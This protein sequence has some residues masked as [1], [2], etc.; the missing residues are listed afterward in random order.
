MR[1]LALL[2]AVLSVA[3]A[4]GALQPSRFAFGQTPPPAGA[5]I[6]ALPSSTPQ[7]APAA[8]PKP[9]P[10]ASK[11]TGTAYGATQTASPASRTVARFNDAN[12]NFRPGFTANTLPANDDESTGLL[13]IGFPINFF[14]HSYSSLYVNNNGNVTFAAPLSAYTPFGLSGTNGVIIAPF[15]ADVDTSGDGSAAVT[16][17]NGMVDGRPAFGVN[18]PGV[19]YFAGHTDKLN[20]FQLVLIDRSNDGAPGDFDIEFNYDRVQWESGDVSGGTLGLGGSS[21]HVGFSNGSTSSFELPG[22]G[23][24]GSFVDSNLTSGLIHGSIGG[25]P[26]GRYLFP[27]RNGS[28]VLAGGNVGIQP[29]TVRVGRHTSVSVA[30]EVVAPPN[31]LATWSIDVGYNPSVLQP[32]GC[33]LSSPSS[34]DTF[35]VPNTVRVTG[36]ASPGLV[37]A[38]TLVDIAFQAIGAVGSNSS[39]TVVVNSFT[40]SSGVATSPTTSGGSIVVGLQGD[41]NADGAVNAV[42]ALCLLRSVA[43]LTVT[44]NCPAISLTLPSIGD[45]NGDGHVNAVDAL[46][47][48]RSVG[49]LTGTTACPA[50]PLQPANSTPARPVR[51]R[52]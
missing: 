43:L 34:C 50:F 8:K 26:N 42:D 44:A 1:R 20:T 37:G 15:F 36:N 35:S 3:A 23:V 4:G 38:L 6:R 51:A 7:G 13:P 46:C 49:G 28:V 10:S 27:V 17:G 11:S 45:V 29:V 24:P 32:N 16:Y 47:I 21:A 48:L 40:D 5:P 25:G 12:S 18:W 30:L 52:G 19:G 14:G 2:L 33:A 41:V 22:S 9:S 39:L 31:S